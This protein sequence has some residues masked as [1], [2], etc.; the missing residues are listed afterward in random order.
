MPRRNSVPSYRLHKQSGQAI[1][2]FPDGCGGR[3]D[4]LL[5]PYGSPESRAEY[6]RLLAEWEANSRRLPKAP[7]ASDLTVNKIFNRLW[8][9]VE[10]HYRRPDGSPTS[11]VEDFK[12]SLRPVRRTDVLRLRAGRPAASE[13][14]ATPNSRFRPVRVCGPRTGAPE[15]CAVAAHRPGPGAD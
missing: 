2:T 6:A 8:P 10:A 3:R 13:G 1:V 12:L 9:Q 15:N 14:P 4:Y 5:G 7:A 11:E